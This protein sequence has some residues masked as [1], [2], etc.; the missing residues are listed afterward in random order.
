MDQELHIAGPEGVGLG[1]DAVEALCSDRAQAALSFFDAIQL[2]Y[3][4]LVA[5]LGSLL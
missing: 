1:T 2:P 3:R 4:L 5:G